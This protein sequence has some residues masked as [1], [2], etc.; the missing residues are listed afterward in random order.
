MQ[1]APRGEG[2]AP[3]VVARNAASPAFNAQAQLRLSINAALPFKELKGE[4][5]VRVEVQEEAVR[6]SHRRWEQAQAPRPRERG[7]LAPCPRGCRERAQWSAA[8]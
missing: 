4:R 6:I 3:R 5:S 1:L 7:R 2:A 8:P